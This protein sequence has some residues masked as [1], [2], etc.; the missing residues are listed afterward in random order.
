MNKLTEDMEVKEMWRKSKRI[1]F[2]VDSAAFSIAHLSIE[3]R[4]K[5]SGATLPQVDIPLRI[6]E[7]I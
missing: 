7:S 1:T 5:C 2:P 3:Q 6:R 4:T